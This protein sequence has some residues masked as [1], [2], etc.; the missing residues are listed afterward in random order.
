M[1]LSWKTF[2]AL[3]QDMAAAAQ[4]NA[5]W[6]LDL[7]VGSVLRAIMEAVASCVLWLQWLVLQVLQA[8]RASTATG[9]DLDSWLADF[10]F[11]RLAA[12]AATGGVTFSR[13]NNTIAALIPV[14]ATVL[15]SDGTRTFAVIADSTNAA[16]NGSNGFVIAA[17]TTSITCTVQDVTVDSTGALAVGTA[18]NVLANTLT[19]IGTAIP[20]VDT[21]TNASAFTNGVDAESDAAARLRFQ[22]YINSLSLATPGAVAYAIST[23]QPGLTYTIAENVN[24]AGTFTAGTFVVTIDNGTGSPGSGL[25]ASVQAAVNAVRAITTTVV[26]QGPSVLTATVALTITCSTTTQHAAAVPIVQAAILAYIASLSVGQALPFSI[27][28]KI[29]YNASPFVT[30]VTATTI[31]SGTSDLAPTQF[32]VVR[33]GT[34]TVS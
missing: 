11:S 26:V 13:Y 2:T 31:N 10:A 8:S 29:A 24:T 7:T 16:W 33:A 6:L 3:V 5:S 23:V 30:N 1:N 17:G 20:A 25:I 22:A 15:S 9:S 21:C 34:V 18:G 4:A 27:I 19:L 32:Q 14:G 12:V 28:A